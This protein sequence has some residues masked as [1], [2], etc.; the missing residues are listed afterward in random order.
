MKAIYKY[1]LGIGEKKSVLMP[2]DATVLTVQI[3]AGGPTLWAL[4]D[5]NAKLVKRVFHVIGTGWP[6]EFLS[7]RYIGTVQSDGFVWH[8]FEG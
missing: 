8:V 5:P 1:P 6:K 2:Q 4:V 7:E 3:Q